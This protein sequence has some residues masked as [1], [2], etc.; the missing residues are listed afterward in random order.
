MTV[1]LYQTGVSGLLA[2]QQ[3]LATVGHNIANVNTEGYTRQRA[4]QNAMLGQREGNNYIGSGTYIE[5]ITR[6]F[7]QFAYKE[8]LTTKSTLGGA[9]SLSLSL[10]QLDQVMTNAGQSLT[11]A[12]DSFYQSVNGIAD[13]PNDLGL[14]SIALNQAN[15]LASNFQSLNQ[16][17]DQLEKSVNG[18]IEQ[19]VKRISDISVEIAKINEQILLSQN[20]R[21]TGQANDLLDKRDQLITELGT[22]TKVNTIVDNFGVT[23]VTIGQGTTLVAG[24]TPLTLTVQAGD[25]DPSQTK[26]F[27][28]SSSSS[29]AINGSLLGGALGAKF[30]FR[31]QHIKQARQEVDRLSL[32]FAETVN[33]VQAQGLDLNQLQGANIFADINSTDMQQGRV[34]S[35][36]T[37]TGTL[38]A[39][40]NI[41][42]VS[43]LPADEFEI[44]LTAGNY[45]LTNLSTGST[46]ALGASGA[47]SYNT[48]LGFEFIESAGVAAN[49]D[50]FII[51]PAENSAAKMRVVM[52]DGA[53]IAA[54]SAVKIT[55]SDNNISP[56]NVAIVT[57]LDPVNAR[58]A[59][60]M[61]IDVL[62]SPAGVFNYT[63]TDNLGVTS[64][65]V[66]Y[67]PP[68]QVVDL[69]PAPA[70]ALFQI[71]ITGTPSGS[72]PSAPEQFIIDD[73][74]GLG[75]G[76]NAAALAKTQN[77]GILANGRNTFTQSLAST[78]SA[79]G[80]SAKSAE[81]V[82]DTAQAMQTQAFNRLQAS[83]G[84]N[85]DEEAANMLKFQQAY[86]ASSRIISVANTIFDTLFQ[87]V[88]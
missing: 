88:R 78:T 74:F 53:A 66:A 64:A 5:D 57:M 37:N 24:I 80:S 43:L 86:Q 50:K 40:V 69:P 30:E 62:E 45:T 2:A 65:P 20:I 33:A 42:D 39:Q 18:E 27:L 16:N 13:N 84:V 21:E 47:G 81:L 48:G 15:V 54:S 41:T 17:F 87:A 59:M 67:T 52:T 85:L 32:A 68:N 51:R 70:T 31:D 73:A 28:S 82:T 10:N 61:R 49:D 71:E 83:S 72:A 38:Q 56:G 46:T 3:Q 6:L 44:R 14:R 12:M 63:Y 26:L 58:A 1:N 79:V 29:V 7:D 60:P 77:T 23:T 34:L 9:E 75:N 76:T 11:G 25:P 8:Q 19:S 36:S 35:P 4:E 22:F 55:P